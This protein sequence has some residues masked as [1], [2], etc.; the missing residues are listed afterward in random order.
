MVLKCKKALFF[1]RAFFYETDF[2]VDLI[3]KLPQYRAMCSDPLLK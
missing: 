3:Y 2:T 1:N